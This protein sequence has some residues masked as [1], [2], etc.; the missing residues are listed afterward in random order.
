MIKTLILAAG[1]GSRLEPLT[2]S[3]P[4]PL[5]PFAGP[6]VLDL[7]LQKAIQVSP[8]AVSVNTHHLAEKINQHI[9]KLWSHEHI[10][11]PYEKEIVSEIDY[12]NKEIHV[13]IPQGLLDL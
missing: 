7:N 2:K 13:I 6:T 1:I 10:L 9:K 8:C 4:K 11:I 3:I 12:V 5:L